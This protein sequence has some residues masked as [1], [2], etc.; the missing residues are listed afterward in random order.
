MQFLPDRKEGLRHAEPK[1]RK[2]LSTCS[3]ILETRRQDFI[4]F[5][6]DAGV[7]YMGPRD[8]RWHDA[9]FSPIKM[10]APEIARAH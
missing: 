3:C 2:I 5:G 9:A 10:Y 7:A 8:N 4:W 6:V 1:H